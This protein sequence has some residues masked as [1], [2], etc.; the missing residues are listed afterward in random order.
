MDKLVGREKDP[1]ITTFQA[2]TPIR[3]DQMN[4]NF[5]ALNDEIRYLQLEVAKLHEELTEL[6]YRLKEKERQP[7]WPF[8]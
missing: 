2:N 3:A 4:Q 8:S 6:R 1:L 7:K 5:C